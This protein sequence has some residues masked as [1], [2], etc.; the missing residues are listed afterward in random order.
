M[1][2]S[3]GPLSEFNK[4][5]DR[6]VIIL[7]ELAAVAEE[8]DAEEIVRQDRT[9]TRQKLAN[10]LRERAMNVQNKKTFK[11]AVVGEF[12]AGKSNFINALLGREIL[13]ISW[14]PSTATK[15]ILT[16]GKPERFKITYHAGLKRLPEIRESQDLGKDLAEFTSD[17]AV[18]SNDR[19]WLEGNVESLAKQIKEVEV[20][21]LA[22][23]LQKQ[24]IDIVDTP[25]L[26]AV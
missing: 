21:C 23:F 8:R 12:N 26:G 18:V 13:S 25:G 22:D 19:E 4:V 16:Y 6:L 11:L 14:K 1:S 24:E 10:R 5:R 20:W 9:E 2:G 7:D 17:P 3:P 15:T